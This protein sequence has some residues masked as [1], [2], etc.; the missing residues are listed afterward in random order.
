M[1][2]CNRNKYNATDAYPTLY[3]YNMN[4]P[5]AVNGPEYIQYVHEDKHSTYVDQNGNNTGLSL[6]CG[7]GQCLQMAWAD[8]PFAFRQQ[9]FNQCSVNPATLASCA[10]PNYNMLSHDYVDDRGQV[11]RADANNGFFTYESAYGQQCKDS[12]LKLNS[13][14]RTILMPD[15]EC[16]KDCGFYTPLTECNSNL[17]NTFKGT[18]GG[19]TCS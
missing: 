6:G 3:E 8:G 4:K 10:K 1:P 2:S 18:C 5:G 9:K 7:Q 13:E 17:C 14:G 15:N 12:E 16:G 11:V 19:N